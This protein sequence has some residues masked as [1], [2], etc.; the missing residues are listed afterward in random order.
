MGHRNG[1]IVIVNE[2]QSAWRT[3]TNGKLNHNRT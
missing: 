1:V 2:S 3:F